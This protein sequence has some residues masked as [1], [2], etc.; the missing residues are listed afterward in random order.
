MT[1]RLPQ[2]F[3]GMTHPPGRRDPRSVVLRAEG[4]STLPPEGGAGALSDERRFPWQGPATHNIAFRTT[5]S[6]TL[7]RATRVARHK[8]SLR[9]LSR[10]VEYR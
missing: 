2:P 3:A 9:W 8:R 4:A 10:G 6:A 7:A 5:A 1:G